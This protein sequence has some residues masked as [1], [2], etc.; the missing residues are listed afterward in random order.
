MAENVIRLIRENV[1]Q[2]RATQHHE[3]LD[4]GMEGQPGVCELVE[5]ALEMDIDLQEIIDEGFAKGMEVVGEKY[6]AEE[7]Y[8][9]DMLA[10]AEAVG[11][12]VQNGQLP[13]S[14]VRV[15]RA[16]TSARSGVPH[17]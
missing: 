3:G 14:Q 5:Q 15:H 9:P 8:I 2:G 4:E 1:I 16:D 17:N 6:E 10:S 7:Y 12:V 11:T 13:E